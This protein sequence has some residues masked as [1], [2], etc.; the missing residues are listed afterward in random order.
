MIIELEPIF[1]IAGLVII[2]L[3]IGIIISDAKP[4]GHKRVRRG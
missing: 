1:F 2:A 3:I 4:K